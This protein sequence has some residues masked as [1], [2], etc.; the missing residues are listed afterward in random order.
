MSGDGILV[1]FSDLHDLIIG[2]EIVA[3]ESLVI[4]QLLTC[5]ENQNP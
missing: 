3:H 1:R 5:L 2:L 4:R